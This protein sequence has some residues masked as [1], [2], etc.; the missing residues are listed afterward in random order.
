[1]NPS[2]P[3]LTAC[4]LAALTLVSC[5]SGVLLGHHLG[6]SSVERRI[7][8]E[9]WNERAITDIDRAVGLSPEQRE[10]LRVHLDQAV[11]QLRTLRGEVETRIS[12]VVG[13]LLTQVEAEMTPE[14]VNAFQALKPKARELNSIDILKVDRSAP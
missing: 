5:L 1:M 10:R 11:A 13:G 6:R 3:L 4:Y 8:H 7:S 9:H 12:V 2:R 14:Q